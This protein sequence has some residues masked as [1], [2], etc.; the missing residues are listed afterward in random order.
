MLVVVSGVGG[1]AS[2]ATAPSTNQTDA[3]SA[4]DGPDDRQFAFDIQNTSTCGFTCRNVTV[5]ATNTGNTTAE[6]VTVS[7]E[8]SVGDTVV[9]EGND[10]VENL[11]P[12]E[13]VTV[14][15]RVQIDYADALLVQRND[16]YMTAN[17]TVTWDDGQE[18]FTE[19]RKVA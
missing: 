7:T 5:T 17:T 3:S 14:T 12:G 2:A 11:E 19:R 13:S 18:T 9:W 4:A 15:K 1:V 10:S 16:G 8:L 6:N